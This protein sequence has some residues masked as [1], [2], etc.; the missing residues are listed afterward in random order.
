MC[1]DRWDRD[2]AGRPRPLLPWLCSGNRRPGL[3]A[4]PAGA[5][6]SGR[7]PRPSQEDACKPRDRRPETARRSGRPAPAPR[8][9]LGES[10]IPRRQ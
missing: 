9:I 4:G 7:D 2:R 10:N 6:R 5:E 3:L 8:S 1:H